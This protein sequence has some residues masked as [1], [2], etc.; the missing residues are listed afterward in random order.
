[1]ELKVLFILIVERLGYCLWCFWSFNKENLLANRDRNQ[2]TIFIPDDPAEF[3]VILV[4][5]EDSVT[6]HSC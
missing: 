4:K 1:M 5:L 2:T 6:W 3:Y